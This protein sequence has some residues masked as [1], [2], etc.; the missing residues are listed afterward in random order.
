MQAPQHKNHAEIKMDKVEWALEGWFIWERWTNDES[1]EEV[2]DPFCDERWH[3][4]PIY[5]VELV[6]CGSKHQLLQKRL[7]SKKVSCCV[8]YSELTAKNLVAHL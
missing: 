6:Q 7:H 3:S 5:H 8:S 1:G 4:M 2:W